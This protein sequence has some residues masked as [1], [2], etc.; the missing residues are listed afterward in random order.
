[1]T[2][3]LLE[4]DVDAVLALVVG[5]HR[6]PQQGAAHLLGDQIVVEVRRLSGITS[7]ALF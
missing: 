2:V 3:A 5:G 4:R 6:G 7:V 1:L